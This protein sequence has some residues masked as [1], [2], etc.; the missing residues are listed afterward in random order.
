MG[1]S[2]WLYRFVILWGVFVGRLYLYGAVFCAFVQVVVCFVCLLFGGMPRSAVM[3]GSCGFLFVAVF[4]IC[5]WLYCCLAVCL[6][7]VLVVMFCCWYSG[8]G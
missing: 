4:V 1:C 8:W 3:F 6:F 2:D 7:C 5:R